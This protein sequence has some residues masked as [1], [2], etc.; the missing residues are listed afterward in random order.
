MSPAA[1][2]I[3][4]SS[5]SRRSTDQVARRGVSGDDTRDNGGL[6]ERQGTALLTRRDLRVGQVRLLHPP[7]IFATLR[8]CSSKAEPLAST[9]KMRVRFSP[10]APPAFAKC[11]LR[12]LARIPAFQAGETGSIPVGSAIPPSPG[13]GPGFGGPANKTRRSAIARRRRA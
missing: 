1:S 8:G 11:C 7:P 10:S 6:A 3:F 4:A 12:L 13:S 2:S 5:R 9:Q